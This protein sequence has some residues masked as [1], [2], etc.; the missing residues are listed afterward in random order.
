MNLNEISESDRALIEQLR[1]AIRE[2][3]LL[4][5]AYDDDFSLLR[6]ITGWDRKIDLIIPKIKFSLRAISALELDKEDFST[7]EKVSAYCDSISEP[8]KYIPGYLFFFVCF[9]FRMKFCR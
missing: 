6:W 8:L 3:L 7:L 2:E 9:F 4:V 5:P 1:E